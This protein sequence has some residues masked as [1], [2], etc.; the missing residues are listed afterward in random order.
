MEE[1]KTCKRCG[2]TKALALFSPN[3]ECRQGVEGTC[4]ACKSKRN[5]ENY[6][7]NKKPPIAD[8]KLPSTF[9]DVV[10]K[11]IEPK[12]KHIYIDP[13][14]PSIYKTPELDPLSIVIPYRAYPDIAEKIFNLA[15]AE[16]RT[17]EMQILYMLSRSLEEIN[18]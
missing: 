3:K 6:H 18:G 16:F 12:I 2:E 8:V 9:G 14:V 10:V 11:D 4:K 7:R 17:P 13:P 1:T 5:L 15:R